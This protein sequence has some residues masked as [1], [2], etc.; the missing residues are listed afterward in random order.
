MPRVKIETVAIIKRWSVAESFTIFE[1]HVYRIKKNLM[2]AQK[3][4]ATPKLIQHVIAIGSIENLIQAMFAQKFEA[5]PKLIQHVIAIGS[6]ENLIQAH[7]CT[8]F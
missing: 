4:E 5:T 1:N 7:V 3:F 2:F 6:I 8:K